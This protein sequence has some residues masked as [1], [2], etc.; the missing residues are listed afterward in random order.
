VI[1][2]SLAKR[3]GRIES[4]IVDGRAFTSAELDRCNAS[5][6]GQKTSSLAAQ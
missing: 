4:F 1:C 5:A 3:T 2:Q 6:K